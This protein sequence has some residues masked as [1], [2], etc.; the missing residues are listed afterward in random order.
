MPSKDK[1]QDLFSHADI[2]L[3]SQIRYLAINTEMVKLVNVDSL[4]IG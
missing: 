4:K 1:L 3:S 2:L